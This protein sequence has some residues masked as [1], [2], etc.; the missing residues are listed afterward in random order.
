MRSR[1]SVSNFQ[2]SVSVS[3]FMSKS[4]FRSRLEIWARS[5]SRRLRSR[6]HHCF[7]HNGIER[8]FAVTAAGVCTFW[9]ANSKKFLFRFI[10]K[11]LLYSWMASFAFLL[12]HYLLKI[13]TQE[14][15]C[16]KSGKGLEYWKCLTPWKRLGL[17]KAP[18]SVAFTALIIT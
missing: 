2:V 9:L 14:S 8:T 10:K 6:L 16:M 4:R 11:M 18:D 3:A 5:R 15:K 13:P 1:V 7:L 17:L 12:W